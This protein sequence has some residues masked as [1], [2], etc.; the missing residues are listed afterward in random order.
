MAVSGFLKFITKR[1]ITIFFVILITAYATISI[2]NF[3]GAMDQI[4]VDQ[5]VISL[6]TSLIQ[7]PYLQHLN[8]TERW[9]LVE[10]ML[11]GI[12]HNIHLDTPFYIRSVVY[13]KNA[14]TLDLGQSQYIKSDLKRSRDVRVILGERIP[15]TIALF[16]TATVINFVI[17]LAVGLYV[18]RHYDSRLDRLLK[19][20]SP[21]STIPS[22]IIGVY[23]IV[24]FSLNL[25]WFPSGGILSSPAPKEPF[26]RLLNIGWHMVLPLFS[27][28][29]STVF[30][31]IVQNRAFFLIYSTEDYVELAKAK[32]VPPGRLEL[33]YILRPALP[34]IITSFALSAINSW[35]GSIMLEALFNW[36]GLGNLSYQAIF[37]HDTPVII[38]VVIVYAYM[39]ALTVIILDVMYG[40]MD[41]R[42]RNDF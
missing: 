18:S 5:I 39:L 7:D 31:G 37:R 11:P 29:I 19:Y 27:W 9:A 4:I 23:M 41:P 20:L 28:L 6:H 15:F 42:I 2:A 33:N 30:L 35:N 12:L 24:I 3:G 22:W 38:G 25:H 36:K 32:G 8:S 16:T 21:I 10:E 40:L 34:P 13:L 17:T 1:I 14:L 26:A